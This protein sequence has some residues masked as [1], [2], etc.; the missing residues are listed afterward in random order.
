VIGDR[1]FHRQAEIVSDLAQAYVAGMHKGG[2]AAT[3][4]HF[5]GHGGVRPDSHTEIAEDPRPYAELLAEDL[6]PF[7]RLAHAGL[8]AIMPAH[9]IYP[10][11]DRSPAGFSAFW[12]RTVLRERLEF[13]GVIL[14]D[15]LGMFAASVMGSL[16][17]RAMAALEAGCDMVLPCNDRAAAIAVLESL[18]GY[19]EPVSHL[20]LVRL[21]G[22][23]TLGRTELM[24][25]PAW[26]QAVAD[27]EAMGEGPHPRRLA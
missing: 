1:A 17:D 23:P 22:R 24:H 4:K 14:S 15:D 18:A 6:V 8:A 13:Q 12:L 16:P 5:P 27:V 19:N 21:H 10:S 25:S 9:V 2:M 7:A 3:G 20:R 26:R 11:V